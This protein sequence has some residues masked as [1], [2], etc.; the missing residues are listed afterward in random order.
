MKS[1]SLTDLINEREYRVDNGLWPKKNKG[2]KRSKAE[3]SKKKLAEK[4]EWRSIV[5]EETLFNNV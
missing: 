2:G 1:T 5:N 4:K 3:K